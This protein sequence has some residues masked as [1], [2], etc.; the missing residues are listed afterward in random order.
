MKKDKLYEEHEGK[1]FKNNRY[2][3]VVCGYDNT[4]GQ[5]ILALSKGRGWKT[6]DTQDVIVT[7]SDDIYGYLYLTQEGMDKLF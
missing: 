6:I 2:V 1:T 4:D 3:G 7:H 5:L